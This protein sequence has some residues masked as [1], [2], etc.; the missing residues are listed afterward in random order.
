MS[1]ANLSHRRTPLGAADSASGVTGAALRMRR[2]TLALPSE[3][4]VPSSG[5]LA[6]RGGGPWSDA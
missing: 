5:G 6:P 4:F 3:N 1:N 2:A